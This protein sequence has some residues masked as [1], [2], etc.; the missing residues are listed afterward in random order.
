VTS[1][2]LGALVAEGVQGAFTLEHKRLLFQQ[3]VLHASVV[4]ATI[5][6]EDVV[7]RLGSA[8]CGGLDAP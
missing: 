1:V 3:S 8:G 5:V 2:G 4:T 6:M 7:R